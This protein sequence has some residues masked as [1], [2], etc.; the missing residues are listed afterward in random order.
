MFWGVI[1]CAELLILDDRGTYRV[2]TDFRRDLKTLVEERSDA[3][4]AT[5]E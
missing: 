3:A 5:Y 4:A 2:S 1:S